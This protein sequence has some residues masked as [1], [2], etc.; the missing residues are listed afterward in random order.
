MTKKDIVEVS[1]NLPELPADFATQ[2]SAGIAESRATTVLGGGMPLLKMAKSGE[3]LFGQNNV[4][5]QPGSRWV[6]NIVSLMHGYV[7]WVD[8]GPG[9]KNTKEGEVMVPMTQPKPMK[10]PPLKG[11]EFKEQRSFQA[12]CLDGEDRGTEVQYNTNSDGGLKAFDRLALTVQKTLD[13]YRQQPHG[14]PAYV[15]P[16]LKLDSEFYDDIRYG[17][18]YKPIFEI[19]GWADMRGNL[20]G[21]RPKPESA[22]P[23]A[24]APKRV[25]KQPV[26]TVQSNVTPMAPVSTQQAHVGQRRRPGAA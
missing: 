13:A 23:P 11:T 24:A 3:W 25:R 8:N 14:S 16:V 20:A 5:V 22:A 21:E 1:F 4:D 6:V 12:K 18:I 15:F 2:L 17:R 7:C 26:E 19:V 9:N 10:P